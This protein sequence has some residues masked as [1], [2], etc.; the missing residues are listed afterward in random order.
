[1]QKHSRIDNYPLIVLVFSIVAAL[2]CNAPGSE[3]Q[4]VV[5]ATPIFE[6][7]PF[8][9]TPT[10]AESGDEPTEDASSGTVSSGD[11]KEADPA[12]S[13]PDC[14]AESAGASLPA[15]SPAPGSYQTVI[16][17]Y[18][19]AGGSIERL[20][21][22]LIGWGAIL[23]DA[24]IEQAGTIEGNA[25]FNGDDKHDF[26][27]SLVVEDVEYI[28]PPMDLY[29]YMCDG[30][31]FRPVY[32]NQPREGTEANNYEDYI[33]D[34]VVIYS[35]DDLT[36]DGSSDLL[37]G[38]YTCGAHTC[39]YSIGAIVW[40]DAA[41]VFDLIFSY[42]EVP[43]PNV[44]ASDLDGDGKQ[45]I[46][47]DEGGIGSVG[48]GVQR[49]Y[50]I[51]YEFNGTEYVEIERTLITDEY[52]IHV[53]NDADEA[54]DNGSYQQA[55]SLYEKSYTDPN[56]RRDFGG[57]DSTLEEGARALE[58]YARYKTIVAYVALDDVAAAEAGMSALEKVFSDYQNEAGYEFVRYARTFL[59][60]YTSEGNNILAA[61]EA[62]RGSVQNPEDFGFENILN[63]FGYANRYYEPVDMC[64]L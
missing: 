56:V 42:P 5:T 22:T 16:Q 40:N 10:V 23:E 28:A 38:R 33:P 6:D 14:V 1:M 17:N 48:A 37:F 51:T 25:D 44:A 50:E 30:D 32:T 26:L 64:P 24:N 12:A 19:N 20:S 59:D 9:I 8:D 13:G 63:Q 34:A 4:T 49:L 2:A 41:Q 62:V 29:I 57:I 7:V 55:I 18:L 46:V 45:E 47:L 11:G 39:V 3:S 60:A 52:Q 43:Y 21:L 31:R 61:C 35:T 27:V 54:F 53:V 15:Q 58:M 36:G